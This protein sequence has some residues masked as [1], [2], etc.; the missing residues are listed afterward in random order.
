MSNPLRIGL[1][2]D[3]DYFIYSA[4]SASETEMDWGEDIWT[5]E[6]DH[7]KARN[8]MFGTIKGIKKEIIKQLEAKYP[9][10]KAPGTYELVDI[11]VITGS[12][13]WRL[14]VLDSYKGNRAAKRKPVGYP[15]FCQK[16]M[17]HYPIGYRVNNREGDDTLGI[18]MS[19]PQAEGFDRI[20]GVSCDKDFN[21]IPGDFFWLTPMK[22]VRNDVY[23]ADKWHMRQTMMG[24]T[25]DGYGGIPGVGEA[26]EG[27]LMAWLDEPKM[28]ELYE[29]ELL[30]GKNKGKTETRMRSYTPE[31]YARHVNA[32]EDWTPSLWDC[33]VSLAEA[34]GMSEEDLLV[35]ARVARILRYGEW[36]EE[37]G[38][39][40]LWTPST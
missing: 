33:M 10:L 38:E 13:N 34:N 31:E 14:N 30:R 6:C 26:F 36:N 16:M 32:P 29:H 24:D 40:I 35:Q 20:I 27:D 21:T 25:T 1:A 28:Y 23:A 22:L 8:I 2:L 15:D 5:L 12:G 37:T 9:K 7:A 19:N 11:C 39:P 17:E 4:M 18:L 3:M